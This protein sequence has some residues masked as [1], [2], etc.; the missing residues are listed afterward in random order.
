MK[1]DRLS[2][3]EALYGFLT[4][5]PEYFQQPGQEKKS[6]FFLKTFLKR[7]VTLGSFASSFETIVQACV[8]STYYEIDCSFV[9]VSDL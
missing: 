6:E 3:S 5:T 8:V 9:I 7:F 1:D 2:H 4:P